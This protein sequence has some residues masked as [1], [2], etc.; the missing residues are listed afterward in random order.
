M[1]MKLFGK[2]IN[3]TVNK[4]YVVEVVG[5]HEY[6]VTRDFDTIEEA[7]AAKRRMPIG[8]FKVVEKAA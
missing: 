6:R 5:S 3:V 1:T 4:Y 7:K 2:E 8:H